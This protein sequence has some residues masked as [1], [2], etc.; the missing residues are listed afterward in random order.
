ML[1]IKLEKTDE[2]DQIIAESDLDG[3]AYDRI[4]N[5]YRLRIKES[6]LDTNINVIKDLVSKA[7][8]AYLG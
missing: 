5:Q 8:A 7:K 2:I 4:W 3:L 1:H 6:D